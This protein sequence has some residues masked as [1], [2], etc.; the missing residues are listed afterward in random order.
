M[1]LKN[2]RSYLRSTC[3]RN[4]GPRNCYSFG[5]EDST[6][7]FAMVISGGRMIEKSNRRKIFYQLYY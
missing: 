3:N 5:F 1:K 6:R 2:E 4:K 7:G